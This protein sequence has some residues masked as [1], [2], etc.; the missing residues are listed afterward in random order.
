M[1]APCLASARHRHRM[2]RGADGKTPALLPRQKHSYRPDPTYARF[3]AEAREA[4][5][6]GR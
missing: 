6:H 5:R 2:K 1:I 4:M 3:Q